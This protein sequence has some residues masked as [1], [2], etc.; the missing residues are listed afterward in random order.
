MTATTPSP[1]VTPRSMPV[2]AWIVIVIIYLAIVQVLGKVLTRDLS[3]EYAAPQDTN[4]IWRSITL[5]VAI[6]LAFGLIIVAIWRWWK[7]VYV[8]DKPVRSW[9]IVIPIIQVVSILAVTNYGGLAE[10]GAAFTALLLVS[11]LLVGFAEELMF[12]GIGVTAF[13]SRGF[14]EGKVALWTT[15]IF[16]LAHATNLF[17][18]GGKAFFQVFAAAVSGYFFS[19]SPTSV[20]EP[21]RPLPDSWPLGLLPDFRV[22]RRGLD[23]PS[24][25]CFLPC[26]R[27]HGHHSPSQTT[28][29]RTRDGSSCD[30]IIRTDLRGLTDVQRRTRSRRRT[31]RHSRRRDPRRCSR[32]A[33]G[34]DIRS[35]ARCR[36]RRRGRQRGWKHCGLGSGRGHRRPADGRLREGELP[37]HRPRGF[38]HPRLHPRPH[39]NRPDRWLEGPP[40]RGPHRAKQ[41]SGLLDDGAE[42][43]TS[44]NSPTR[45]PAPPSS[46]NRCT[47]AD[48]GSRSCWN[49]SEAPTSSR[50]ANHRND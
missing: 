29:D 16:G 7:P 25:C 44:S 2:W 32:R 38:R 24:R 17:S 27:G 12:R 13:R 26:D 45:P 36:R 22:R 39:Q 28:Q 4:E 31:A 8:D 43:S 33:T 3:T 20:Q 9:V 1:R 41:I 11:C 37:L 50:P 21:V 42:Q 30:V 46:S 15:V 23:L 19:P 14:T 40:P 10:K 5:P 47:L 6:S 49:Y 48:L 35:C 34:L 18:E